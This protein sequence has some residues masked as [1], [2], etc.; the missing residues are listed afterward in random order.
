MGADK[1]NKDNVSQWAEALSKSVVTVGIHPPGYPGGWKTYLELKTHL[2]VGKE[3]L[4][5]FL[6]ELDSQGRL[7]TFTGSV[8][9]KTAG[10]CCRQVWYRMKDEKK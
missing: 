8:M 5:T 9:S 7:E 2:G 10:V 3:K 4:K 1:R 6:R